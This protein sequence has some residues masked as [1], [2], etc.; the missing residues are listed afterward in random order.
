[1]PIGDSAMIRKRADR[2][3]SAWG[4]ELCTDDGDFAATIVNHALAGAVGA[5]VTTML[6]PDVLRWILGILSVLA[7]IVIAGVM[8][9]NQQAGYLDAVGMVTGV[10][11]V[12]LAAAATTFSRA[13][14]VQTRWRAAPATTAMRSTALPTSS[15]RLLVKARTVF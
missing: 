10:I 12:W 11:W 4:F 6:G 2:W 5:W 14:T 3:P 1:M 8:I 7:S 13:A 15:S 9:R